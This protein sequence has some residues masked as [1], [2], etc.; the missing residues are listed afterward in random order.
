[1]DA[2]PT[3]LL[4]PFAPGSETFKVRMGD[5]VVEIERTP[6]GGSLRLS[7]PDGARPIEIVLDHRGPVLRLGAPLVVSIEGELTVDA[8]AIALRATR[9]DVRIAANDDVVVNGERIK[10][11]C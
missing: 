4:Q 9:G 1:M 5:H 11:N 10:L 3:A 7:A 6:E 8:D 2:K